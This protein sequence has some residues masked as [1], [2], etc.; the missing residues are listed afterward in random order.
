MCGF[1]DR[2][3][4]DCVQLNGFDTPVPYVYFCGFTMLMTFVLLNNLVAVLIDGFTNENDRANGVLV[5][6]QVGRERERPLK[7]ARWAHSHVLA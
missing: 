4:G 3:D 5:P 7:D 2:A 1:I 6:E